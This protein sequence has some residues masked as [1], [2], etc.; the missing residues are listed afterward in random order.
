[1]KMVERANRALTSLYFDC[2]TTMQNDKKA[3]GISGATG[4]SIGVIASS[5][6]VALA[7][8]G[9][10]ETITGLGTK[11]A[12]LLSEIYT[13]MFSVITVLT[14]ILVVAALVVRMNA[15]QQR[16][17]QATQWLVRIIVCYVAITCIGLLLNIIKNTTTDY[18]YKG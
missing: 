6:S 8:E 3:L 7:T 2:L 14:A 10:D 9:G 12:A 4:I 18:G 1:M 15:N 16:A 13:T 5:F 17:A 11:I